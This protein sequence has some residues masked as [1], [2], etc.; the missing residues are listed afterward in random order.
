MLYI[1]CPTCGYLLG[2]KQLIYEE[3]LE[4][5]YIKYNVDIDLISSGWEQ[6]DKLREE[7]AKII[8]KLCERAC[9]KM[10]MLTYIDLVAIIK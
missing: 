9:C 7:R 6:N 4:K 3:E 8:N 5:L 10:R 1:Q 2:T